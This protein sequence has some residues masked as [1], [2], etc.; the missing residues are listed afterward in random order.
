[1]S[2]PE[3]ADDGPAD[4]E[5]ARTY[6]EAYGEGIR[7][8]LKEVLEQMSRG[9]DGYELRLLVQS[10]LARLP[11]EVE[12]KRRS[13]LAPPRLRTTDL[14]R[15]PA[16]SP[17]AWSPPAAAVRPRPGHSY[18][19]REPKPERALRLLEA[20]AAEFP[21]VVTISLAP[22][23]LA[24][25]AADRRSD[26]PLYRAVSN[27]APDGPRIASVAGEI[28]PLLKAGALV[29][30]DSVYYLVSQETFDTTFRFLVWLTAHVRDSPSALVVSLDPTQFAPAL[31]AQVASLM[32]DSA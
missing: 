28:Q 21:R 19:V 24:S 20:A 12:L 18:L 25:V 22:P 4:G 7:T 1:M 2:D 5:Y 10:R 3:P 17:R 26:V 23:F 32:P 13:L 30:L 8:S 31:L 14:L 15:A 6:A 9:F 29:Y 27:G 16:A 11:E